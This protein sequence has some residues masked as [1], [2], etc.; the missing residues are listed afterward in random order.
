LPALGFG[1]GQS[2]QQV[3]RLQLDQH[4]AAAHL[5]TF[6]HRHL[7]DAPAHA[8]ADTNIIRFDK[9]RDVKILRPRFAVQQRR[10]KRRDDHDTD[11]DAVEHEA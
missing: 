3:I 1:F 9:P 6:A 8:R 4:L 7:L 10:D 11:H 5:L 2:M